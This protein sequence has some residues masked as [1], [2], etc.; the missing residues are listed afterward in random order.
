MI[1]GFVNAVRSLD[2]DILLGW[3]VQQG[4]L[5]YITDRAAKLE[6]PFKLLRAISRTPDVRIIA[7]L[8]SLS[9]TLRGGQKE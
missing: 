3:E 8:S 7:F 1:E 5:G 9:P 4:S 6:L 2:P